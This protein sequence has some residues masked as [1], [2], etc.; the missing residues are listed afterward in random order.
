MYIL[1]APIIRK[2]AIICLTIAAVA[3]CKNNKKDDVVNADPEQLFQQGVQQVIKHDYKDAVETFETIER[4]H[5]AS[6]Y[7]AE[8]NIRRI[9]THYLRG[10]FD[11]AII[12]A[13]DFIKQYPAHHNIDYAYYMLALC[14][15]D[16]I[17]DITRDQE[18]TLKAIDALLEVKQ[19]FPNST[20]ALDA[21]YKLDLAY[22]NLAGKEMEVGFFYLKQKNYTAAAA[23]FAAVINNPNYERTVFAPEALYRLVEVNYLMGLTEEAKKYAAVLGYNH[24]GSRWYQRAYDILNGQVNNFTK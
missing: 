13:E 3:S 9:Y 1:G 23:R 17:V 22:S 12:A 15:Y 7:A 16:Q 6:S 4:E 24:P 5:P 10:K 21:S 18:N 19:R 11:D 8:A 2:I 20:Y 14:Y